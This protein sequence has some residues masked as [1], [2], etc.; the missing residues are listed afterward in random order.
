[1]AKFDNAKVGDKVWS[2]IC[3]DGIIVPIN[4][5][6]QYPITVRFKEHPN[7]SFDMEG[8]SYINYNPE[9]FWNKFK[10]PTDKEDTKP[11]DLTEYLRENLEIKEFEEGKRNIYL[12][13]NY[14]EQYIDWDHHIIA[15]IFGTIYF[16]EISPDKA[17]IIYKEL[18]DKQIT[19]EQLKNSYKT[20]G[21]L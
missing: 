4:V 21:W 5:N 13:Y 17:K 12:Y 11:F 20:L 2:V 3:G 7:K 19:P 18:N 15:E 9:L 1:M 14:E 10:I 16:K 6:C 8:R